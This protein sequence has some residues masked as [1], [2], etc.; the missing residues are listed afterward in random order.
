M[1]EV[2][3]ADTGTSADGVAWDGWVQAYRPS[4]DWAENIAPD[5]R[6]H[7]KA[8]DEIDPVTHEV[9]R[10]R[11]WMINEA[12]G[13]TT[14]RISGS[15][16]ISYSLD[17]NMAIL[18]EDAEIV[19]NAPYIQH[20]NSAAPLAIKWVLENLSADPGIHD[21][22]MFLCNDP[23]IGACHQPDVLMTCPV[24][25]EGEIFAWIGNT[26]N[27]YDVGGVTPGSWVQDAVDIYYDPVPLS[28][29]KLVEKGVMRKDLEQ[30]YLRH[31]RMP[32]LV[33]L[34][35]RA[36]IAG[37]NFARDGI[38]ELIREYGAET[39]KASM[40]KIIS[41]AQR[42]F[43]AKL[44]KIPDGRWSEVFYFT[45]KLPGDRGIYRIQVNLTKEGDRLIVDNEGTAPQTEGPNGI[46]Y[47]GFQG[48]VVGALPATMAYDQL[49]AI[50]GA[51]RQI[52]IRPTPGTLSC[53]NYPAAVSAGIMNVLVHMRAILTCVDRM[54]ACDPELKQDIIAPS[55][56]WPLMLISGVDDRGNPFGTAILDPTGSGLGACSFKDGVDTGGLQWNPMAL[57]A[58]V[59]SS[60]QVW[61]VVFLYRKEQVDSGGAGRWRGGVG[62]A[63]C[64][65]PYRTET[66][67]LGTATGGS[68][69]SL[70]S[71]EGLF[72]GYPSPTS[73]YYLKTD[74]DIGK[75]FEERRIPADINDLEASQSIVLAG[76]SKGTEQHEADVYE[77]RWVGGGGFGDPLDRE[78]WRV[79]DDVRLGYVSV[80]AA[81][82]VY[83]VS[84]RE[85]LSVDEKGTAALRKKAL[86][87]RASWNEPL[88]TDPLAGVLVKP[89]T[90][91]PTRAV[92]EYLVSR[93][94]G[95]ARVLACSKCDTVVGG[96]SDNYKR[97]CK[98]DESPIT[99]ISPLVADPSYFV[100]DPVVFRRFCCP[101]CYVLL[102][103]EIVHAAEPPVWDMRLF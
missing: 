24:F 99:K 20:M 15:P 93:D 37:C 83:A 78:P 90:G 36:Q 63:I 50:G 25:W 28:P 42:A 71:A 45:E 76:K 101:G 88:G 43:I 4:S 85:D 32:K 13:A 69:I 86:K 73:R 81:R 84:L 41:D 91:E 54:L 59:E 18:T 102:A 48:S 46:T 80:E 14:V 23:W 34:D 89:A 53:V 39:V 70:Y 21:G 6:L 92:H 55:P 62:G 47:V 12:H 29:F 51:L 8:A 100:D 7:T 72:G 19:Y 2:K 1:T 103:V 66:I 11:L 57:V 65:L 52:E 67:H 77:A 82:D 31:S 16:V 96:Y 5:V 26:A 40:K 87:A 75:W 97:H 10:H 64:L 49:F 79:S 38:L 35:L 68:G 44:E 22:D 9:I 95:D 3:Q 60:E 56:D 94:D 98:W 27:Q 30:M 58:N 17:F 33:G 74:T 61:P